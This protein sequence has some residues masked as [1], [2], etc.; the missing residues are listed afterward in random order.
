MKFFNSIF[1]PFYVQHWLAH[2][3]H[4]IIDTKH[5][6]EHGECSEHLRLKTLKQ[7]PKNTAAL[8]NSSMGMDGN[9]YG[10]IYQYALLVFTPLPYCGLVFWHDKPWCLLTYLIPS[11]LL[12]LSTSYHKYLHMSDVSRQK[13]IPWCF[14][15]LLSEAGDQVVKKHFM[16]H[17]L[18][19]D[20]NWNFII[21]ADTITNLFD[22]ATTRERQ[23]IVS[24]TSTATLI[25]I[26][27][28][29]RNGHV[30]GSQLFGY[31][32]TETRGCLVKAFDD[33]FRMKIDGLKV[34]M[35]E[36]RE[37]G[38][39]PFCIVGKA[40]TVNTAAFDNLVE[41][42]AIR[43]AENIWLCS[44]LQSTFGV[45]QTYLMKTIRD[46]APDDLWFCGLGPELSR[47]FR[48]LK[49]WFTFKEH[50][51]D[52]LG[53]KIAD[54]CEQAQYFARLLEKHADII[55]VLRPITLNT[56]NFRVIPKELDGDDHEIID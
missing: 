41:L 11:L 28:A 21:F 53:Q 14:R 44:H 54:N 31:A 46:F 56:V 4:V 32:S 3:K 22:G 51:I 34:A 48:A 2:H 38:L 15:W 43:R 1:H 19:N 30:N 12:P 29:R 5:I 49:V 45:H 8:L 7:Y 36:D 33:D 13:K 26:A 27:T 55:H 40:G 18:N 35:Q 6:G 37:K 47:S 17:Y 52:K 23:P 39:V 9:I 25:S 10:L 16:H 24:E 42:S 50:G 20:C